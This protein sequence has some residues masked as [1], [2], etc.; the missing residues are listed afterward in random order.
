MT[1]EISFTRGCSDSRL[2]RVGGGALIGR[3]L[4]WPTAPDGKQ[5]T[6]VLSLP[7]TFLNENAG[8]GI[9]HEKFVSVFSYYD[10]AEYFLDSITYHG[11]PDELEWLRK[12]YTK[13]LIHDEGDEVFGGTVI[14][15][16]EIELDPLEMDNTVISQGSKVGGEPG[17]LQ[18][19]PLALNGQRFAL[20]V[21]GGAYPRPFQDIFGL[22]DAVGYLFIN[23]AVDNENT[24]EAGTFFVQVT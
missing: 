2:P 9:R 23:T 5:L 6:L 15:M 8:S 7:A 24:G 21:Y 14:P 22:S 20:Q 10:P 3:L 4:E 18:S 13:V 17:L 16:M 19:E 12:G 11:S 1:R